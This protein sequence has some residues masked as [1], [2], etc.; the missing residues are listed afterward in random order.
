MMV[1]KLN[2]YI[3]RLK[4]KKPK[5][6]NS[7]NMATGGFTHLHRGNPPMSDKYIATGWYAGAGSMNKRRVAP[8]IGA[9]N[10]S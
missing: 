8:L 10:I 7:C 2:F 1:E 4:S 9:I 3:N 5:A 6:G